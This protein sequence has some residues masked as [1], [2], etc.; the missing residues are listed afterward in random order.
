MPILS[1]HRKAPDA[2]DEFV[3]HVVN[4]QIKCF[5]DQG[6]G[7]YQAYRALTGNHRIINDIMWTD[8][9]KIVDAQYR[10]INDIPAR[11]TKK[12]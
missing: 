10:E 7:V 6:V 5:K 2:V 8:I 4:E 1:E 12:Q 9:I 11:R 3:D